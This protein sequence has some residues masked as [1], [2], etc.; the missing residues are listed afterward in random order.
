M[1]DGN[2]IQ[3]RVA[4]NIKQTVLDSKFEVVGVVKDERHKPR[5]VL[6][7]S[8]IISERK[9]DI[10]FANTEAHRFAIAFHRLRRSK[11]FLG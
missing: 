1:V 10:L 7:D 8:K 6:G 2:E 5:A 9:R 3:R 4:L 11:S